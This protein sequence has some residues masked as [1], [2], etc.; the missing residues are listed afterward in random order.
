M[1]YGC[2]N[3]APYKSVVPVQ[4]GYYLDGHTSAPRMVAMPVR[5]S[6]TCQYTHSELG[7]V[8]QGCTGCKWRHTEKGTT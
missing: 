2:K 5:G 7:Q 4:D 6:T 8:D 3:R 1:T